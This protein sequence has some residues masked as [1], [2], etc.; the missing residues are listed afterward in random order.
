M[1]KS[2]VGKIVAFILIMT[3]AGSMVIMDADG[4]NDDP[5]MRMV[6]GDIEIDGENQIINSEWVSNG[7]GTSEDPYVLKNLNMGSYSI[8]LKNLVSHVLL[9]NITFSEDWDEGINLNRIE[10]IKIL[11]CRS[12]KRSRLIYSTYSE[13]ISIEGLKME[14]V[15]TYSQ[16]L[17]FNATSN[18][19]ITGSVF[20]STYSFGT[21]LYADYDSRIVEFRDNRMKLTT[22]ASRGWDSN[23][24]LCDN[25][26]KDSGL[27]IRTSGKGLEIKNNIFSCQSESLNLI[28]DYPAYIHHNIFQGGTGIKLGSS[29]VCWTEK[30]RIE[31]NLFLNCTN[32]I[33]SGGYNPNEQ[34]MDYWNINHNLF[35]NITYYAIQIREGDHNI[36][37][38]NIFNNVNIAN[39]GTG[40]EIFL[41]HWVEG[42]Q[43]TVL[44]YNGCGNYWSSLT[45]LDNDMD[46]FVDNPKTF[47]KGFCDPYPVTNRKFDIEGPV[48]T[49]DREIP[50]VSD[51]GYFLIEY[52]A[53]DILSE[54]VSVN[55]TVDGEEILDLFG[56]NLASLELERGSHEISINAI[57]SEN[58]QSCLNKSIMVN[59]FDG[60]LTVGD[61][62]NG[63]YVNHTLF[64]LKWDVD[65]DIIDL[66]QYLTLNGEIVD[67]TADERSQSMTL[68]EGHNQI[69]LTITDGLDVEIT[70]EREVIC[71][72]MDPIARFIGPADGSTISNKMIHITWAMTDTNVILEQEFRMD[73][74]EWKDIDGISDLVLLVDD[75]FHTAYIRGVDPA[76]N[77]GMDVTR[78]TV[79]DSP[80]IDI[81]SPVNGTHTPSRDINLNWEY[82]GDL[83]WTN[84]EV[85]IGRNE[86]IKNIDMMK[87]V[88]LR[89]GGSRP[90]VN[91]GEYT[92]TI[93][94]Y[95]DDG[96]ILERSTVVILDR[97][98]PMIKF[99]ETEDHPYI[100]STSYTLDWEVFDADDLIECS[101]VIDEGEN[102]NIERKGFKEMELSQGWHVMTMTATDRSGNNQVREHKIFVDSEEPRINID[103]SIEGKIFL[104]TLVD[105][106]WS[107]EDF[108][109][110]SEV[111]LSLDHGTMLDVTGD[112]SREKNVMKDG[113]HYLTIIAYDICRNMGESTVSFTIDL[114][115]PV[116]KEEI[117]L[118]ELTNS[119]N[120]PFKW[121]VTDTNGISGVSLDID[122]VVR[123]L[124]ESGSLEL[125]L[126]SGEHEIV[127]RAEDVAGRSIERRFEVV[128]DL[129]GPNVEFDED[130]TLI[131][132]GRAT[133]FWSVSDGISGMNDNN[134]LV[135]VDGGPWAP[136]ATGSDYRTGIL[137]PGAH[138]ITV[139]G[140]DTAG[141]IGEESIYFEIENTDN[142]DLKE[143]GGISAVV[144]ILIIVLMAGMVGGITILVLMKKKS[145]KGEGAEE[146]GYEKSLSP[147]VRPSLEGDRRVL[148]KSLPAPKKIEF[149]R[150]KDD[151]EYIR[152]T[153]DSGKGA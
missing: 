90:D 66:S 134:I 139:R 35:T 131:E 38:R 143:G 81:I 74:G 31:N 29:N 65:E 43:N 149:N 40:E 48:I 152:P 121:D 12:D 117:W 5:I 123:D 54:V 148:V 16:V 133:I 99:M 93:S 107:V 135:S 28:G 64:D 150:P 96:N 109:E 8:K 52:D 82:N 14:R 18:I 87:D 113:A 127:F 103:D 71:D 25:Y 39:Y 57:D 122:G 126:L 118:P 9:E 92:I 94:I 41:N 86:L 119:S 51:S 142:N 10:N 55:L 69:S 101:L 75:G 120:V 22:V 32:G 2:P 17:F 19:S 102:M 114:E 53:F 76:G 153:S 36:I 112:T 37:H 63:E 60:L 106:K 130:R 124:E 116:I 23:S 11:N 68:K 100:N 58:V 45:N 47:R 50:T 61:P 128:V 67:I 84:A 77:T 110:V 141:N 24:I 20:N 26:F 30:G 59:S 89:I 129:D 125:D 27:R 137:E 144:L 4:D 70:W 95:L 72:T 115:A 145:T 111:Y 13:N 1:E 97:E 146:K 79:G 151:T 62:F 73:D 104:D 49:L 44:H 34:F 46:G 78:F 56:R 3:L 80:S 132:D 85:R 147:M 21:T 15:N 91:D 136:S 105:I 6:Y 88:S 7:T 33:Y 108:G 138:Q 83:T 140:T 98:T 42:G